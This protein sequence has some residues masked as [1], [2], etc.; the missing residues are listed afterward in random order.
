M[1][2]DGELRSFHQYPGGT[3]TVRYRLFKENTE[4]EIVQRLSELAGRGLLA[5]ELLRDHTVR[6]GEHAAKIYKL[7]LPAES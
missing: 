1:D 6:L 4:P 3:V 2:T 5:E 7:E